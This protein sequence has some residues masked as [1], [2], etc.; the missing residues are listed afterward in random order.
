MK[1]SNLITPETAAGT[2]LFL[3]WDG[4]H[5]FSIPERE[6]T[7]TTE[8][9]RFFG[10]GG[11]RK[12]SESLIDCAL[13]ESQEE[14]GAVVSHLEHAAQTYFVDAEGRIARIELVNPEIRPRLILEK[15]HHSTYGS[16]ANQTAPY[17]L[18]AFNACLTGQPRPQNEIASLLYLK[19]VHLAW[20]R[21]QKSST[22]AELLAQGAQIESQPHHLIATSTVLVP[23][24]TA[25]FLIQQQP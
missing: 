2:A 5:V 18:V 8:S 14:I 17:Y 6:L 11:K 4:Y 3:Q 15:R 19:D 10:V 9:V 13:R 24:G 22:L 21:Q 23:H 1:L 16:M 20:L 12:P 25:N 7:R